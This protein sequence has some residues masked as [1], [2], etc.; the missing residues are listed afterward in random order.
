MTPSIAF[1]IEVISLSSPIEGRA[2]L[3]DRAQVTVERG[4]RRAL[5]DVRDVR[6]RL[7]SVVDRGVHHVGRA[8]HPADAPP[9]HRV[10]LRDTVDDDPAIAQLGRDDGHR[11]ELGVAVDE[12]FVDLVT[13]DP[14]VVLGGPATD[15][16]DLVGTNDGAR[17][18]STV[19]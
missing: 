19:T 2:H 13:D 1:S 12:V 3:V 4:D 14:D 17:W 8:D 11:D 6:R 15:R 18:G 10:G 9:G 16:R 7:D 5:G